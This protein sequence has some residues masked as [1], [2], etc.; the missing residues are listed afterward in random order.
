MTKEAWEWKDFISEL[1]K[2]GDLTCEVIFFHEDRPDYYFIISSV[3]FDD[4]YPYIYLKE[5]K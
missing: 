4:G 3:E 5:E 1:V 2:G